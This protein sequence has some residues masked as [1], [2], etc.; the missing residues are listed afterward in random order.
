MSGHHHAG[1]RK[2]NVLVIKNNEQHFIKLVNAKLYV[3]GS[4]MCRERESTCVRERE[5][6]TCWYCSYIR[7]NVIQSEYLFT[8][9]TLNQTPACI[10]ASYTQNLLYQTAQP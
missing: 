9:L 2:K 6:Q 8:Y 5:S 1:L 10:E 7:W 3:E 4:C